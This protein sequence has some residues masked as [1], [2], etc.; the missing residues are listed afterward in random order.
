MNKLSTLYHKGKAGK[1]YSW[2]VWTEG[3]TVFSEAGTDEGKKILSSRVCTPKNIGKANETTAE[4]QAVLEA[5]AMW[6]HKVSRKYAET[7]ED[8]KELDFQ[9]M[10]AKKFEDHKKKVSYPVSVQKKYNGVRGLGI[11]QENG[12]VILSTR[13]ARTWDTVSHINEELSKILK[14]G[15]IIDGEIY[16][17]PTEENGITF[18]NLM[19]L[20]K[21]KQPGTEKLEYHCYDFIQDDTQSWE[22]RRKNLEQLFKNN[23]NLKYVK[24]VESY[25][26]NSEAEIYELHSKFLEENYEGAMV[27]CHDAPY[28]FSYRT[29][30]LLKVKAFQDAEFEVIGVES[31]IGKFS[32]AAIFVLVTPEG[33][34]FKAIPKVSHEEKEKMLINAKEYIGKFATIQYFSLSDSNVP[35]F[36]VLVGFRPEED[37][38]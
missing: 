30:K 12:S 4:Q 31:G 17:H 28:L 15:E 11:A 2:R 36:P 16:V 19:S 20:V 9:P 18:Q 35:V 22:E 25:T 6:K 1:L 14:P 8:A 34:E 38:G 24:F 37:L 33:K 5:T 3:D 10:L 32:K 7:P 29:D 21:R 23:P 27:R 26:A 13:G